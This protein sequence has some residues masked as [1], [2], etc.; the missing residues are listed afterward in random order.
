MASATKPPDQPFATFNPSA[1]EPFDHRQLCH[2]LR[3]AALGVSAQ[4]L[5]RYAGQ[6]PAQVVDELTGYDPNH[7]PYHDLLAGL[8]GIS[9]I[10]NVVDAQK[11]WLLRMLDTD[12]PFQERM[13]LFWH[14]HFATS[15]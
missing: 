4:R 10:Y 2:L 14:N 9:P 6:S 11:W 1:A 8:G 7:D 5:K 3:R 13:A 15:T 12:A